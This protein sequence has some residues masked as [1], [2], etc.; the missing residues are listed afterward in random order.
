LVE[1]DQVEEERVVEQP[2]LDLPAP[3][4]V[5]RPA[6]DP[7]RQQLRPAR[8]RVHPGHRVR[9]PEEL[10]GGGEGHLE[11]QLVGG[12]VAVV[13]DP[14]LVDGARGEVGGP[15]IPTAAPPRVMIITVLSGL[16]GEVKTYRSFRSSP[17]LVVALFE[18]RG[19]S[20][21]SAPRAAVPVT[22][23]PSATSTAPASAR[24]PVVRRNIG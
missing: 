18:P 21:W 17:P 16:A 24:R 11:D 1:R 14:E 12:R 13:A 3:D 15:T 10:V 6:R 2:G 7:L 5:H 22:I 8:V 4:Q 9:L 23:A 19:P 20:R